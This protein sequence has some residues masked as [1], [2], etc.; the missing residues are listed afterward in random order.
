MKRIVDA[1]GK[2]IGASSDR[3]EPLFSQELLLRCA[4]RV[5]EQQQESARRFEER[6]RVEE[7]RKSAG[8]E[9]AP[10]TIRFRLPSDYVANVEPLKK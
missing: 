8:V 6:R 3:F 2:P 10:M 5:F 4:M 7:L 1:A 9:P